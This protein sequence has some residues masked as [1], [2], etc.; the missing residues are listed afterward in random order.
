MCRRFRAVA[1]LRADGIPGLAVC[2][3]SAEVT[4]L[5]EHAD[6]MVDGPAGVVDLLNALAGAF[7]A[8]RT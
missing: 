4:G 1:T 3:G 2:S 5:A 8:A 7:A 6:L